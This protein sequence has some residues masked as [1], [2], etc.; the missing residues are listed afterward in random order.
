MSQQKSWLLLRTVPRERG[1]SCVWQT[2][3]L[4]SLVSCTSMWYRGNSSDVQKHAFWFYNSLSLPRFWVVIL[5]SRYSDASKELLGD[6]FPT[7][8]RCL[9]VLWQKE[10]TGR[11]TRWFKGSLSA[12]KCCSGTPASQYGRGELVAWSLDGQ[13]PPSHHWTWWLF[14]FVYESHVS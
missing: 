1:R 14:W 9:Q 4:W 3:V 11:A 12:G 13:A 5:F 6:L 8:S 10:K 2:G 7:S